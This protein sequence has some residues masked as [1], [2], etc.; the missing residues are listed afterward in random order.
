MLISQSLIDI[1]NKLRQDPNVNSDVIYDLCTNRKM[2]NEDF[3]FIDISE[4]ED[5]VTFVPNKNKDKYSVDQNDELPYMLINPTIVSRDHEVFND[6]LKTLSKEEINKIDAG[7]A[8]NRN[9][10]YKV[11]RRATATRST[12]WVTRYQIIHME[13]VVDGSQFL[14]LLD[15]TYPSTHNMIISF[16]GEKTGELKIGRF[17]RKISSKLVTNKDIEGV[18]NA[19]KAHNLYMKNIKDYFKVV[20][21]EDIRKWY[22]GNNYAVN[23]G[24]LNGSCMRFENCQ[25]FFNVYMEPEN[26][27][28]MLILTNSSGQLVCRALLWTLDDGTKYM[29]RI[30]GQDH[31]IKAF[32]KWGEENDYTL[33]YNNG[34]NNKKL[35]VTLK[36]DL[37]K[38]FPYM[39][40]FRY[41]VTEEIENNGIYGKFINNITPDMRDTLPKYYNMSNTNGVY[42]TN[43]F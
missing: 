21:G 22:D 25:D 9:H 38:S 7:G 26:G 14:N 29:D 10:D 6:Y 37:A 5:Y 11:I 13:S 36:V 35:S 20:E 8:Y 39:D 4:K 28:K 30:Y 15:T 23:C 18:V 31:T 32:I 40:T 17:L 33:F 12:P 1:L 42:S 27:V 16:A 3:L 34:W 43:S 2:K 24:N 19:Y 41:M